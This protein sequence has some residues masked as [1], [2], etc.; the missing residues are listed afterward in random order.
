MSDRYTLDDLLYLMQRLRDPQHGC[1]WDLE[2][3]FASIVPHTLEEAY[4]VADAIAMQDYPQLSGELGDLLFQ[5]VYYAQLGREA[6]HFDWEQVVDGITRKLVR[7]H[8]HVFPDGNLHT[9]AGTLAI[10]ADQVKQRWEEI[11]AE[12]RAEK[13][14]QPQQLSLLDDVPAALPALSRAQK[15]QKRAASAGFDWSEAAPVVAKLSEEMD[16]IRE[17]IAE[18]DQQAV[19]EEVGDFL[20]CAVNLARH[21]KVDAETALRDGNAKFE[22]RFRYIEDQLAQA[23]ESIEQAGLARLDQ[24]WDEAKRAGL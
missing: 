10:E 21:L 19:A 9:P 5:V 7:R 13:A 4:E 14:A 16:E 18:G 15:L 20:F 8:P 12:E 17:A 24:L 22:R 6:G 3:D 11:K 2:Q 23:G 1:P